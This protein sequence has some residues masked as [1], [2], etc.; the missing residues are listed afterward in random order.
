MKNNK[1]HAFETERRR[2][3]QQQQPQMDVFKDVNIKRKQHQPELI[4][5]CLAKEK[6][7]AKQLKCNT[8]RQQRHP[9]HSTRAFARDG[10][11][12]KLVF[13]VDL[14]TRTGGRANQ[15]AGPR[16]FFDTMPRGC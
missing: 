10:T 4:F 11:R 2:Q 14:V 8:E 13:A 15:L 6:R 3:Q 5:L 9:A 16:V 1:A 7:I 12:A